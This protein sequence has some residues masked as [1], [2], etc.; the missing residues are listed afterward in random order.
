MDRVALL[1]GI[2]YYQQVLGLSGCVKD[3]T[4]MS[5]VLGRHKDGKPNYKCELLLGKED[6]PITRPRLRMACQK[7]FTNVR[8]EVAFYFSGHGVLTQ[9]G[10]MLCTSDAT[11]D[12][13]GIPM[14]EIVHFASKSPARSILLILDCCH[15]GDIA[16][17]ALLNMRGGASPLRRP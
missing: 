6:N 5:L 7:L 4:D 15:S 8:G 2:N 11:K 16:N 3:A 14:Q 1:V 17:P 10:G 9:S 13:W 12:D